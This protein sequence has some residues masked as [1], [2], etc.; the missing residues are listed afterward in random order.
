MWSPTRSFRTAPDSA[1][2]KGGDRA[3]RM[4]VFGDM[5]IVHAG[6]TFERLQTMVTKGSIDFMWQLGDIAYADDDFLQA[7]F[8]FGYEDKWDLFMTRIEDVTGAEAAYMVL[9]GNHEAECHS[10]ACWMS[11]AKLQALS[12]FTAYNNR[13]RMPSAESGG[14]ANMWYSWN[15]GPIHFVSIDTETDFPNSFNDEWTWRGHTNGDFGDQLAWLE[16]QDLKRA[17]MERDVRPWIVVGGHR[18]MYCLEVVDRRGRPRAYAAVVQ[19]AFEDLF[20]TYGVDVYIAGHAHS[21]ER[22]YPVYRSVHETSYLQP[23]HT[24]HFVSGAAGNI[25]DLGHY[26]ASMF[27]PTWHGVSHT[28]EFGVSVVTV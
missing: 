9:P 16:Q 22:Q 15:Y 10:P 6:H 28:D 8:S 3:V 26:S 7:P 19:A 20:E 27:R 25:E 21:Y 2:W 13:F 24:V 4:A 5:G 1:L 18:P 12:N 23:N 11:V 14:A 17:D